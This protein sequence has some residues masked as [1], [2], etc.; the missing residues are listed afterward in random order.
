LGHGGES[1]ETLVL[2]GSGLLPV[3]PGSANADD[4]LSFVV[5]TADGLYHMSSFTGPNEGGVNGS[6]NFGMSNGRT[7]W[8][9][10]QPP[11]TFSPAISGLG[12]TGI[13]TKI[14]VVFAGSANTSTINQ[15]FPPVIDNSGS[16]NVYQLLTGKANHELNNLPGS[17][18]NANF[19]LRVHPIDEHF[20][21][22]LTQ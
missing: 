21:F 12:N 13:I 5:Q 22:E 2:G 20:N 15:L 4:G 16:L 11:N 17:G 7:K 3:P 14:A 10:F 8:H 18:T 19:S 6:I 9:V 1:Y